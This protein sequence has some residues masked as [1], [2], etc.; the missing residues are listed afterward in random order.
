MYK[1]IEIIRDEDTLVIKRIDVSGKHK[2]TITKIFNQTLN[3]TNTKLFSVKINS[4]INKMP[5]MDNPY[6]EEYDGN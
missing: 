5:I 2:Q 6:N 1:Y 4:Y 3:K